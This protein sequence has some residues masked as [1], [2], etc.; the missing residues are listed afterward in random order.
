MSLERVQT[1]EP[2]LEQLPLSASLLLRSLRRIQTGKLNVT[3][4]G[5]AAL[6][7]G[8][9]AAE[10][11]VDLC[12]ERPLR[13]SS[14]VLSRGSLGFAEA[15]M[16]GDWSSSA[17][18]EL[19]HLL[20]QNREQL[21]GGWRARALA[22]MT[23]RWWH[24]LKSNTPRG[25]KKN[26]AYHYDLSNEFYRLWL[27]ESMSYSSALFEAED[28]ALEIAQQRKYA[29]ILDLIDPAP[30]DHILE[31]GCGWGR[32]AVE[33][34]RRDCK[35]TAITLSEQQFAHAR[36]L[37]KHLRLEKQVDIRLQDYRDVDGL[38]DHIV[39][40][41][42]IE[43]VG[44]KFWP[45]YFA[46]LNRNLKLGGRVA[47]QAIVIDHDRFDAYRR[48]PDFIQRYVFPGGMLFSPP[49]FGE[50]AEQAGLVVTDQAFFGK[51][52][53][54]TLLHWSRRFSRV[55]TE[56][57]K[58]GFEERFVRLWEYYLA[59]CYAGFESKQLELMQ[60]RLERT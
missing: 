59:Y 12:I 35:V 5:R 49:V 8:S 6:S 9:A 20:L 31:I 44:E 48:T 22:Q 18:P 34:A 2:A 28:D 60:V 1:A 37:V 55:S 38:Y 17:L 11:A 19:L 21:A 7:L 13:M 47:L 54:K 39:S 50:L 32:F 57:R 42:M 25:S 16:R 43:A 41:E 24:H 15:Y 36:R 14:K 46:A 51:H 52:Y 56:V 10:L 23:S 26:I 33:A 29:R 27:D 40:I 53:A 3:M 58:L 4:P 30:G 45:D